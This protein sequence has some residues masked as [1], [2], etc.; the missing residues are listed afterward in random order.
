[1]AV[2]GLAV[3]GFLGAAILGLLLA[4]L[5]FIIG[6]LFPKAN[7]VVP[8]NLQSPL[9]VIAAGI[10]LAITI[11]FLAPDLLLALINVVLV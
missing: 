11:S 9:Q 8:L 5:L 10:V 2:S 4:G 7:A 1:M 6:L 3:A